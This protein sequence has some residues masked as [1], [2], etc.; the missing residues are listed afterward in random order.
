M[1]CINIEDST[2]PEPSKSAFAYRETSNMNQT[3]K[4][5]NKRT[6]KSASSDRRNGTIVGF[7]HDVYK[8]FKR[9]E[10]TLAVAVDLED[11][12]NIGSSVQTA[13]GYPRAT[14]RQLDAH[15]LARSST[16]G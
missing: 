3:N 13:G 14:W 11:A 15:E 1:I 2:E 7:C 10:Q 5:T 8:G 12:Y 6:I 16:L 9:K 4:Q